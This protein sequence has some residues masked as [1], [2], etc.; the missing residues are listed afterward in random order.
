MKNMGRISDTLLIFNKFRLNRPCY[1]LLSQFITERLFPCNQK[2]A[3]SNL[4]W[5][6]PFNAVFLLI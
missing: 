3:H 1:G 4:E 5:A 6:C 2:Q